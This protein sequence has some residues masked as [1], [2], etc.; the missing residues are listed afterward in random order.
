MEEK[1]EEEEGGVR[2]QVF[3]LYPCEVVFVFCHFL[4]I[5]LLSSFCL[6]ALLFPIFKKAGVAILLFC[7]SVCLSIVTSLLPHLHL[8]DVFFFIFYDWT[9]VDHPSV[10]LHTLR[11]FAV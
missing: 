9:P 3:L 2:E 8:T 5:W 6:H 1:E 11:L 4:L 10:R 7:C